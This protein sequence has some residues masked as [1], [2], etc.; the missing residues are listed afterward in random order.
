MAA[1]EGRPPG[2]IDAYEGMGEFHDLFMTDVGGGLR[3]ALASAFADLDPVA[4]VLDLGAGTGIGTRLLARSTPAQVI[5]IE[6]SLT[7]RAVLLARVADDAELVD[8][9]SVLAGAAPDILNEVAGPVA[10]FV[11]AH[12]LGHLTAP[13]RQQ[14]FARLSALLEPDGIGII[15]LPRTPDPAEAPVVEESTRIGRHR[16]L[17][18]HQA[19]QSE[20]LVLDGDRILR[21]ETFPSSWEPPTLDQLHNELRQ[22]GLHLADGDERIGLVRH[23][24]ARP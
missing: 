17:A 22:A 15:T 9:V 7:M 2:V 6:P 20:Y 13:Q 1:T 18:R 12:M 5:A 24:E 8:R 16:Y 19:T 14:T 23:A 10:G 4:T 3:P 11:C 21:Q